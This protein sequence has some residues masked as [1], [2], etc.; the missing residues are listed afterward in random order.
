MG[1]GE[2]FVVYCFGECVFGEN[3]AEVVFVVLDGVPDEVELVVFECSVDGV[4]GHVVVLCDFSDGALFGVVQV[5]QVGACEDGAQED[6]GVGFHRFRSRWLGMVAVSVWGDG[7]LSAR[8]WRV[9]GP[10]GENARGVLFLG[11]V[12]FS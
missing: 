2:V 8:D 10:I 4:D 12:H 7:R 6:R 9:F 5:D 3:G 11:D 1:C